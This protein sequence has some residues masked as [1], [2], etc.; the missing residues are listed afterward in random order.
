MIANIFSQSLIIFFVI[1]TLLLW[2]FHVIEGQIVRNQMNSFVSIEKDPIKPSEIQTLHI[3]ITNSKIN[4]PVKF[5]YVDG[6]V[7]DPNGFVEH[8]FAALT[9]GN[10]KISHAWKI[11]ENSISGEY[12]IFLDVISP[13]FKPLSL[14]ETFKILQE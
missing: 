6:I 2:N 13:G 5:A 11:K 1:A 8:I 3:Q 7:R 4:E 14:I 10:G 9:D 12:K